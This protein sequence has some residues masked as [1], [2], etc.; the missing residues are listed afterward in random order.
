MHWITLTLIASFF[1]AIENIFDKRISDKTEDTTSALFF[2]NIV[3]IPALILLGVY[4]LPLF[5]FDGN[6]FA[7]S[8]L[9]G[10]ISAITGFLYMKAFQYG[11]ASSIIP[12]YELGPLWAMFFGFIILWELPHSWQF[13]ALFLLIC[14]GL[15]FSI[16]KSFFHSFSRKKALNIALFI[17][18]LA[19][20][21]YNLQYVLIK[22]I[23]IWSNLETAFFLQQTFY[24]GFALIFSFSK[25]RGTVWYETYH[26]SRKFIFGWVFAEG[27]GIWA[28]VLYTMAF[29]QGNVSLVNALASTQ[30]LFVLFLSAGLSIFMP[31]IFSEKWDRFSMIQKLIWTFFIASGV[32]LMYIVE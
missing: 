15:I 8:L 16:K 3:K 23:I 31:S 19:S 14:G 17:V 11:D 12:I 4:W 30:T 20:L 22:F 27:V 13:L 26:M 28:F 9:V 24:I 18:L 5:V 2:M 21:G 10:V 7:W 25:S 29:A 32:V 1:F 6:I